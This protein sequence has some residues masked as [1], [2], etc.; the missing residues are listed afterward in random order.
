MTRLD[1]GVDIANKLLHRFQLRGK[2]R[3]S[4]S[5]AYIV[6]HHE[7][8]RWWQAVKAHRLAKLVGALERNLPPGV[9]YVLTEEP[10]KS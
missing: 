3:L 8:I 10:W 4:L 6:I 5:G 1:Y 9:S 2:A 7:P